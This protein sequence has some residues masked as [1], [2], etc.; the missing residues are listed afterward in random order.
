MDIGLQ[1]AII[2]IIVG[3]FV[4]VVVYQRWKK[5]SQTQMDIDDRISGEDDQT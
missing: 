5:T 2:L 4:M 3:G 1:I